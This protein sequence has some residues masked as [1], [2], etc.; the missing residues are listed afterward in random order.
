MYDPENHYNKFNF[1]T[2]IFEAVLPFDIFCENYN[3]MLTDHED[4]INT[5]LNFTSTEQS[6]QMLHLKN[7]KQDVA[8][9][10]FET[11]DREYDRDFSRI[12]MLNEVMSGE[13]QIPV[14]NCTSWN[15]QQGQA[16]PNLVIS[17]VTRA[18]S[19]LNV[20]NTKVI[21]AMVSQMEP[22]YDTAAIWEVSIN[23]GE[24]FVNKLSSVMLNDTIN[25]S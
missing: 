16:D 22:Q 13:N 1:T 7:D 6:L 21:V 4:K 18:L 10:E 15:L 23:E 2:D 14:R 17:M 20:P 3:E 12:A 11:A 25:L 8:P 24:T 5:N 19:R 9:P